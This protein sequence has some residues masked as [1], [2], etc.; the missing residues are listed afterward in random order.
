[1]QTALRTNAVL[2]A[3]AI[4]LFFFNPFASI[5]AKYNKETFVSATAVYSSY[6]VINRVM[7]VA[8][9]TNVQVGL[10]GTSAGFKPGQV[11]RSLLDTLDRFADLLFPLMIV[12]GV[13]SIVIGPFAV[14]GA[15]LAALGMV[16]RIAADHFRHAPPAFM[17]P[18][19]RLGNACA[20]VGFLAALLVPA[21]YSAGYALG[22]QITSRSWEEAVATFG[23]FSSELERTDEALRDGATTS[24]SS[25]E[26]LTAPSVNDGEQGARPETSSDDEGLRGRIG[27]GLG[28]FAS[29]TGDSLVSTWGSIGDAI[30]GATSNALNVGNNT[31]QAFRSV[32]SYMEKSTDLVVAAFQFLIALIVKTLVIPLVLVALG[33]WFWRILLTPVFTLNHLVPEV[34]TEAGAPPV[35]VEKEPR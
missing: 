24:L 17:M 7:S 29:Q 28:E 31:L 21:T 34:K 27:R 14:L 26:T 18:V 22:D 30:H 9:D 13:M 32:P 2:L 6:R 5:A 15:T 12:A 25:T 19:K 10:V 3:A 11:L 8:A 1:M 4:F 35:P 16:L 20:G 23:A 33:L